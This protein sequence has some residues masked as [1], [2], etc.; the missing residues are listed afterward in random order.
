MH[1]GNDAGEDQHEEQAAQ[2][3]DQVLSRPWRPG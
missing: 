2:E 1:P 3:H